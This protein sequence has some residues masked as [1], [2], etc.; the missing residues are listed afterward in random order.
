[1]DPVPDPILF[2]NVVKYPTKE[3]LL[4]KYTTSQFQK[5]INLAVNAV[6]TSHPTQLRCDYA[7]ISN[8]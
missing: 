7:V 1:V 8:D 5:V 3:K 4:P 2:K 6:F